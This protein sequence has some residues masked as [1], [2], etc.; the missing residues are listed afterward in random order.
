MINRWPAG[1]VVNMLDCQS[2]GPGSEF[3]FRCIKCLPLKYSSSTGPV[4]EQVPC[5]YRCYT[6]STLMNQAVSNFAIYSNRYVD[7]FK[8]MYTTKTTRITNQINPFFG[9][10][11]RVM[12]LQ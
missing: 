8:S 7:R 10:R 6:M 3:L 11:Q 12:T 1:Q 5:L 2:R 9:L 4:Q